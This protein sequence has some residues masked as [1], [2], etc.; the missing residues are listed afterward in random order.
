MS[1]PAQLEIH[2][3]GDVC[4]DVVGI[5]VPP[6][7]IQETQNNWQLTGETRPEFL[8]GGALLLADWI[9]SAVSGTKASVS[10]TKIQLPEILIP[11]D[12]SADPIS[13]ERLLSHAERLKREDIVHSLL[14]LNYFPNTPGDSKANV[15]RVERTQGFSGP[16][17]GDPKL[18]L[19]PPSST[20]S[21]DIL[22]LD[23]TGNNFRRDKNQWPKALTEPG[24]DNTPYIVY[25][26][27][28]PL[29]SASDPDQEDTTS[30]SK[31]SSKGLWDTVKDLKDQKRIVIVSVEDLRT[32]DARI[33]RGLSW[34]RTALDLVWHLMNV[35][36]FEHL[37]EC[38]H[39]IIKLDLDGAVYWNRETNEK[40]DIEYKAQLIYDP[41]GIEGSGSS[42]ING[43]MIGYGS[44]FTAAIVQHLA[45]FIHE[46]NSTNDIHAALRIGIKAGLVASRRL[47]QAGFGQRPSAGEDKTRPLARYPGAELFQPSEKDPFFADQPIPIIPKSLV[48]DRGYWRLL[49]SIFDKE[50]NESATAPLIHTA[51][52]LV[53]RGATPQTTDE[54]KAMDLLKQVPIAVFAKALRT[55]DRK[56]IENYRSLYA[57]LRNYIDQD[58]PERPLSVA[59]F[60][61]PGA[62]KSFGVKMVAKE[63]G[64]LDGPR[65]I[66]T[67]TFNISQYQTPDQLADA[68][69]LVRDLV[70]R[71]RIPLV[72]FDEFDTSLGR[73]KLGWLR[74]FLAPM[75]DGE[76]LDRGTPH[77]IG[78]AIFVFAGG[79]H[80]TYADFANPN[81]PE[82]FKTAKGPD[83]L[84]RLRGILDIPGLD[85]HAEFDPYGAVESFPC[86]TAI[87]LRRAGILNYQLKQKAPNFLGSDKALQ[88]SEVVLRTLLHI[89][90]FV[91]GNRSFEAML[92]MSCLQNEC[93]FSP[94]LLPSS[95][96]VSLH[97]DPQ[98]VGQLLITDYPFSPE[99]REIIAKKIH[100][101]YCETRKKQPDFD[102]KD[103]SVKPWKELTP[104]LKLSNY[105]QA[106]DIPVKLRTVGLWYRKK[107]S[108]SSPDQV[109]RMRFSEFVGDLAK[110]EHDRW[111]A[112]KRRNGWIASANLNRSSKDR[113]LLLHNYIH[114]WERLPSDAKELDL[115]P[116]RRIP[117]Q[118]KAA[119]FEIIEL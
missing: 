21:P 63:L 108:G 72:F 70:L 13:G 22:V 118:L 61:P 18:A 105:M 55:Y 34:E 19:I 103:P 17:D 1:K 91:H 110:R 23:D 112:E 14:S 47:L 49:D 58:R 109:S 117:E 98:Q 5:P 37:R 28:R 81:S 83:F 12:E 76:F 85:L 100:E 67:L 20:K 46:E 102:E 42:S 96:S 60:G 94:C 99:D 39:L 86:E 73:T 30:K 69:H 84:S 51:T 11:K 62:G 64:Q 9:K 92:D 27:H 52:S 59:V 65:K 106:D 36:K 104:D 26:L 89:P 31:N 88:V 3:A 44:T 80:D 116:V 35:E 93:R 45:S 38:P 24:G 48:P 10:S 77:P 2:V 71:G 78:Q 107:P 6:A 25:K 66:E 16:A 7:S 41:Q 33:S 115:E 8:L 90:Q 82:D 95:E 119:G 40:G 29:P 4:L 114:P 53:A 56:E 74:Y 113:K 15:L 101:S 68:F 54:I 111:V 97:A 87:L 79:T 32:E 43:S 50:P 57:L 75:Q